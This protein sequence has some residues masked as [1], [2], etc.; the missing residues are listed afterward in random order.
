MKN[1]GAEP[2]DLREIYIFPQQQQSSSEKEHNNHTNNSVGAFVVVEDDGV[3]TESKTT[4]LRIS[5]DVE[6]TGVKISITSIE[7]EYPLPYSSIT[8]ILPPHETRHLT[9]LLD[10][11]VLFLFFF[12]SL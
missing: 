7:R 3:S 12:L 5:C 6:V 11:K 2:D 9:F 10:D 1:I 8:F 4:R